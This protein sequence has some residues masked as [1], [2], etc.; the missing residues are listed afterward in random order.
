[1]LGCFVYFVPLCQAVVAPHL[2]LTGS[3][4]VTETSIEAKN[5][6]ERTFIN[7]GEMWSCP[8]GLGGQIFC[9]NS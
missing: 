3:Q 4:S 9:L 7:H 8:S 6:F 2:I 1:M 5:A